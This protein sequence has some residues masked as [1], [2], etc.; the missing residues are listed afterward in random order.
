MFVW[1]F[2]RISGVILI[3]LVAFQL[4]TGF[5]R[6]ST[7]NSESVKAVATLHKHALLN[8]LMVFL[9]TF[10]ALYGVRTILIDLGVKAEKRLF[11]GCTILGAVIFGVFLVLYLTLVA[12]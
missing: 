8:C 2:H 3:G 5:F 12:A 9:F 1:I 4:L 7:A 10:H 11:W 6:E